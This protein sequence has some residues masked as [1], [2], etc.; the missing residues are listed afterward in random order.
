MSV[1]VDAVYLFVH[2]VLPREDGVEQHLR[3][4][5]PLFL[6]SQRFVSWQL[7]LLLNLRVFGSLFQ[8]SIE[9]LGDEAHGLLDIFSLGHI[10]S[11]VSTKVL[12]F[13]GQ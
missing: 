3:A 5:Y 6:Q 11:F 1:L 9:I 7:V 2:L 10:E 13:V 12:M 4:F 8:L